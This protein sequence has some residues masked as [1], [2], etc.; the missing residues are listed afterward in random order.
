MNEDFDDA[1]IEENFVFCVLLYIRHAMFHDVSME[2]VLIGRITTT[3]IINGHN[4][5]SYVHCWSILILIDGQVTRI[6][7]HLD[8]GFSGLH[9]RLAFYISINLRHLLLISDLETL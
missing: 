2:R 9:F 5:S 7:K 3:P 6:F 4:L 1:R 8:I